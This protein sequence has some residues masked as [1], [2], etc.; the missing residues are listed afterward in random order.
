MLSLKSLQTVGLEGKRYIIS[1]AILHNRICKLQILEHQQQESIKLAC[2]LKSSLGSNRSESKMSLNHVPLGMSISLEAKFCL[3]CMLQPDILVQRLK[4]CAMSD[5]RI[6]LEYVTV[7][8]I[9]TCS[10]TDDKICSF[11][12]IQISAHA[13]SLRLGESS[14][15]LASLYI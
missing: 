6:L 13:A 7:L 3:C 9:F 10:D 8:T 15:V 12:V 4:H 14:Q 1:N 2:I 11:M 5:G